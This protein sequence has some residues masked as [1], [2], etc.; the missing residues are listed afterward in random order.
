[1]AEHRPG[2]RAVMMGVGA[3]FDFISGEKPQAPMWMQRNGME[4]IF[5]LCTEPRRLWYRYAWHNPRFVA[6]ALM[7]LAGLRSRARTHGV[8]VPASQ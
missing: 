6:L 4:W 2:V 3:A 1:M 5:R 7:Q 8:N